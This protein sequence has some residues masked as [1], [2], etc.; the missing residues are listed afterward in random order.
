MKIAVEFYF[1][2]KKIEILTDIKLSPEEEKVLTEFHRE[3][4]D[5]IPFIQEDFEIIFD[6]D[7]KNMKYQYNGIHVFNYAYEAFDVES[8]MFCFEDLNFRHNF[9][10]ESA[11][12]MFGRK[13]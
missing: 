10:N 12:L 2:E 9:Y 7:D 5:Y 11:F 1:D 6:I 8:F 4:N 13:E 3:L